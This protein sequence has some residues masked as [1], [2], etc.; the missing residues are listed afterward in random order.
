MRVASF[1]LGREERFGVV[2]GERI[3]D[4]T[5]RLSRPAATLLEA[6]RLGLVEEMRGLADLA[7]ADLKLSEVT[8]LQPIT[9]PGKIVCVGINYHSRPGEFAKAEPPP[10]PSL[11]YRN[12]HAQA[13]HGEPILRP[14]ESEQLDY[15]GE[16][17][18]IIGR[19]GRRIPQGQAMS[20]VV[21]YSCFNE[22]SIR[23]WM[24]HGQYNITAGKNFDRSGAFGPWMVTADEL[25]DPD[26]IALET[27]VNGK[28]VQQDTTA[29]LI[30]P[31]VRLIEYIST[32]MTL[33]PGDV[34][35]TGTPAGSGS[36]M[37]P[38]QWLV[39]GD[40]LEVEVRGIGTLRNPI[41]DEAAAGARA[42]ALAANP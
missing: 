14:P 38:P 40:V 41:V 13:A 25:P 10:Y 22:G 34:I 42:P 7:S 23:D 28:V 8:L 1:R 21:G 24:R 36:K 2:V 32:F 31:F 11:F 37:N 4:M 35:C 5:G 16:V 20:H 17:A 30:F 18:M 29:N 9:R 15:E 26:S 19:G 3:A 39:P 12:P 33:D 6:I 27:R